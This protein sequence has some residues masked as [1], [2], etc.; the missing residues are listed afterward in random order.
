VTLP[1]IHRPRAPVGT[2]LCALY[3]AA[4]LLAVL[5]ALVLG[6]V[7]LAQANVTARGLISGPRVV[8]HGLLWSGPQGVFLSTT[9]GSRLIA[10]G[11]ELD[12]SDVLVANG[13]TVVGGLDLSA[14][15]TGQALE[16]LPLQRR[17]PLSAHNGAE[18]WLAALSDGD[19][20]TVVPASCLGNSR[21]HAQILVHVRLST[22]A[23]HPIGGVRHG[24]I[25]LAIA[26]HR[27]ALTYQARFRGAITVRVVDAINAKL[28]YTIEEPANVV[29]ENP[30][31]QETQ[32]DTR[33]NVLVKSAVFHPPAARP[34]AWWGS[35][36]SRAAHSLQVDDVAL[37]DGRIAYLIGGQI[38]V[39]YLA[40]SQTW[41]VAVFPGSPAVE[42][43]SLGG[44]RLAWAQRNWR[45][46]AP[47][48][49]AQGTSFSCVSE[50]DVGSS[51]LVETRIAAP[52]SPIL[53]EGSPL[54]RPTTPVCVAALTRV[55]RW[56]SLDA[57]SGRNVTPL[58]C[59]DLA[60]CAGLL[61]EADLA[62]VVARA[63]GPEEVDIRR[64][65]M[66]EGE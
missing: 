31:F 17:C 24:A 58:R 37:S 40:T 43:I 1:G 63:L 18:P 62:D 12:F 66:E 61:P 26:G 42:T 6:P 44:N 28:L 22:G 51:E 38:E 21:S 53:V 32:I 59:R 5:S 11:G 54:E 60:R 64:S 39:R 2:N 48:P 56:S 25:A 30:G 41:T 50:E 15:R 19:L 57:T 46:T 29:R 10:R 8:E 27:V 52:A 9:R 34:F 49:L 35:S 23:I 7:G 47:T 65:G 13:W 14:G 4:A 55:W 3:T 33:G 20:Y 36:R 45:F 16:Q